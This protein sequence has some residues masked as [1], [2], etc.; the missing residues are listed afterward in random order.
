MV[1]MS[2]AA[3]GRL[4]TVGDLYLLTPINKAWRE[5][6]LKGMGIGS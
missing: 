3:P 5:P 1:A 2:F 4:D 6:L